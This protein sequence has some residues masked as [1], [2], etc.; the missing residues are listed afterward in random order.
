M[1]SIT[2]ALKKA[3]WVATAITLFSS[4]TPFLTWY[5]D[6]ILEKNVVKNDLITFAEAIAKVEQSYWDGRTKHGR[7][8][9][10]SNDCPESTDCR[11]LSDR[12]ALFNKS[13]YFCD[14][15]KWKS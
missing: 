4:E 9:N 8:Q 7:A 12:P 3:H 14:R 13:G 5:D 10:F 6:V 15:Q 1:H 11:S 2:D